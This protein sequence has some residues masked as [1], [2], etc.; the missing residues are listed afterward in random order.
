MTNNKWILRNTIIWKKI[1]PMPESVTDRFTTDFEYV[2]FFVKNKKYYFRQLKEPLKQSSIDRTKY[3][4]SKNESSQHRMNRLDSYKYHTNTRNWRCVWNLTTESVREN[5][6]AVFP[7]KLIELLILSGCKENSIVLDP[8]MGSGTTA[9]VALLHQRKY[10]G[11]E[12]NKD[13]IEMSKRRIKKEGN[14]Q[15]LLPENY[16]FCK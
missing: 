1:N 3:K 2:F 14:Q 4:F 8:F 7:K 15:S 6:C 9:I 12:I 16:T 13:Y 10:I 11:F 5:H